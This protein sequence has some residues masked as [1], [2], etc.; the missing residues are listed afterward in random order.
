MTE[1]HHGS[2]VQ[3]LQTVATFDPLKGEFIIDTP[4]DGAIKW[5][6]GNAAVHGKF[7]T[8]FARLLLPS[9]DSKGVS[10]MGVHAFIVPIR[11]L[12]TYKT[13]PGVEIHDC[14]HKIGLNG[15]D[16]SKVVVKE[17]TSWVIYSDEEQK[18]NKDITVRLI[19]SELLSF[20]E[21]NNHMAELINA[22]RNKSTTVFSISLIQTLLKIDSKALL[23]LQD[24]VDALGKLAARPGSHESLKQLVEIAKN[25]S[26]NVM[27]SSGP[28]G[29]HEQVSKR[30]RLCYPVVTYLPKSKADKKESLLGN[31]KDSIDESDVAKVVE[32]DMADFK[33]DVQV[34]WVSYWK[35]K[36]T[37]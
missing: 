32:E 27:A 7:A 19:Q 25:T 37:T 29:F 28:A 35:L 33:E 12:K 24:L 11:D 31:T 6:I 20:A 3:G 4:N 26:A 30:W 22:E 8:V 21:Y 34:E 14:G 18:F 17:L 23:E 9:H 10:D 15:A 16:I 2:N 36:F 13:L 5:W 1:L